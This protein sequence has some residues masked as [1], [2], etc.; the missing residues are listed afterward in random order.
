MGALAIHG[1]GERNGCQSPR[2]RVTHGADEEACPQWIL[3]G[4]ARLAEG[5]DSAIGEQLRAGSL[6]WH[7][8]EN[9]RSADLR[10]APVT[11]VELQSFGNAGEMSR[12]PAERSRGPP[13]RRLVSLREPSMACTI[14]N[15]GHGQYARDVLPPPVSDLRAFGGMSGHQGRADD[16]LLSERADLRAEAMDASVIM[17]FLAWGDCSKRLVAC[18]QKPQSI[19]RRCRVLTSASGGKSRSGGLSRGLKELDRRCG[20]SGGWNH[21]TAEKCPLPFFALFGRWA[22]RKGADDGE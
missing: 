12:A 1:H 19:E 4:R 3:A 6:E 16:P 8:G 7:T 5:E 2:S 15:V 9:F 13:V 10:R 22:S 20:S 18:C 21:R 11:H 17:S 14:E